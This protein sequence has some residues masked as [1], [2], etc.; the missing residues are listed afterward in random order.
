[1]RT[2]RAVAAWNARMRTFVMIE[3]R[4]RQEAPVSADVSAA[5]SGLVRISA[6]APLGTVAAE[7]AGLVLNTLPAVAVSLAVIERKRVLHLEITGALAFVLDERQ[8]PAGFGPCLDA[9]RTGR[10]VIIEDTKVFKYEQFRQLIKRHG[11]RQVVAMPLPLSTDGTGQGSL[12]LYGGQ[13]RL[14]PEVPSDD[15]VTLVSATSAVVSGALRYNAAVLTAR[16]L[17][18]AMQSRAVI[19]QAKGMI[20]FRDRCS[21]D[22]AFERL[23]VLSST[24]HRKLRDIATMMVR[25]AST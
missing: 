11:V 17:Q 22:E 10:A 2:G 9:A 15:L 8:Y 6:A 3:P 7:V 5:L 16:Q 13:V 19:E 18:Q 20:M 25:A 21:A 1:M 12:T 24:R 14:R 4:W 23:V